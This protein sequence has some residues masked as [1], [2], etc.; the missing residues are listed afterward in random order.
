VGQAKAEAGYLLGGGEPVAAAWAA[1]V[2]HL[3]EM[4]EI[5]DVA[6]FDT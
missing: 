3:A 5:L 6:K 1:L 4:K 2:L